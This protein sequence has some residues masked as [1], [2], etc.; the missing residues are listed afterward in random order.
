MYMFGKS[1]KKMLDFS[2]EDRLNEITKLL[3]KIATEGNSVEE[4]I[5]D[6]KSKMKDYEDSKEGIMAELRDVQELI[7]SIRLQLKQAEEK[8]GSINDELTTTTKKISIFKEQISNQNT[9]LSDLLNDYK[10]KGEEMKRLRTEWKNSLKKYAS[11]KGTI[12]SWSSFG[13]TNKIESVFALGDIHGWAPG[14]FNAVTE[15]SDLEFSLLGQPLYPENLAKRFENPLT[16]ARAG[17]F[18]PRV[19]LNGHPLRENS[20]PTPFDGLEI[21]GDSRGTLFV[22]VGDLIDRGD[23]N[24]LILEASRQMQILSPGSLIFTIGNHESWIIEGDFETWKRNEDRYRMQGRPRPGTTIHDP[25]MTGADNLEKSMRLSFKILEGAVG[26]SL[27]TQHFSVMECLD[28]KSA[29]KFSSLYEKS[30][31]VLGFNEKKLKKI[32]LAGGW[33]LHDIGRQALH[34]WREASKKSK[35]AIPGSYNMVCLNGAVF[36]HAEPN[37]V[38]HSSTDLTPMMTEMNFMGTSMIILPSEIERSQLNNQALLFARSKDDDIRVEDGLTVLKQQIPS[39]NSVVHGHTP[40]VKNPSSEFIIE[41]E[42]ITVTNCDHG[43]TPF[44]R[45]LR[46]D[47]A[48]DTSIVPFL[49]E[50]NLSEG[51]FEDE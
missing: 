30:I 33:K 47:D 26:A 8:R 18:L 36:M 23:H 48:Y 25:I 38:A 7:D 21:S 9:Q 22:Q 42:I 10:I 35:I 37:G 20:E 28:K 13:E 31:S 15:E 16:A 27:L 17:R 34:N 3:D 43:M 4:E 24:E 39:M 49:H 5:E 19:G 45:A 44:Y 51:V 11:E 32:V 1:G 2:L 12:S 50:V 46:F 6:A 41:G 40:I 29:E 14:F